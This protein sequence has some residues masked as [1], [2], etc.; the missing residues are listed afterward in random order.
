VPSLSSLVDNFND[1]VIGPDW[2]NSYGG[3]SE[4]GGLAHVPCTTGYAGFQTSYTWTLAGA[5]FFVKVVSVPAASTATEAYASV[6]V[7][8][9]GIGVVGGPQEGYRV[10]FVINTV[11]GLL[12]CKNDTGY[13]DAG[14]VDITYNA[15]THAFLRLRE[16]GTN[17]YWDTSPDGSTWTNRRTL[18]TPAWV[19]AEVGT[20]A[21]DLS[22]HR[23]AGT[24]DEVTYDL[25]NTLSNGAVYTATATLTAD[26]SLTA[27]AWLSARAAATLTGDSS[28]TAALLL[29]ARPT[30]S[31]T[32]GSALTVDSSSQG[33]PEVAQMAAGDWDLHIEQGSTFV[34]KYTVIDPGFTWD[35]WSARSQIRSGPA[36][37]G[38][39]LL[40]L[41]PHLTVSGAQVM[42]SIPASVTQTLIR[43]GVWDLEMYQD[44]TVVRILNG[45]VIISLEVTR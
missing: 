43:N 30:V 14:S 17:V 9:P 26:S 45:K 11:T 44:S 8:A 18:A 39:L 1:G 19:A 42:L 31:L 40:D 16:D 33:I 13:F 4:S 23:D 22:A 27:A 12:R 20:C 15:T 10:G 3:A 29:S 5:S 38:D 6:F 21:L 32:A 2:G 25:F 41:T 34:Q 35:G 24:N 36:D 28:L 37:S 7:N